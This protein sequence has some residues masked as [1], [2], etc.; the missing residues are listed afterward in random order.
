MKFKRGMEVIANNINFSIE[1]FDTEKLE[2]YKN[3]KGIVVEVLPRDN[4]QD[5]TSLNIRVKFYGETLSQ[6][7]LRFNHKELSLSKNNIRRIK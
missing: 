7:V 1:C 4:F 2:K 6:K 3:K 5:D